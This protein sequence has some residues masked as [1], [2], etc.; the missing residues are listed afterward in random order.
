M[1]QQWNLSFATN[2]DRARALIDW[3][4]TASPNKI[5]KLVPMIGDA[6]F[7]RYFRLYTEGDTYVVMDAPPGVE[8]VL[9]FMRIANVLNA[10]GLEAPHI[11]AQDAQN[12]FLLLSDFGDMTYLNALQTHAPTPL[13][14]KALQAL[15]VLYRCDQQSPFTLP[16]FTHAIMQTE[17][18]LHQRWFLQGLLGLETVDHS[19]QLSY[20]ILV[21]N[22]LLQPQVFM[23][24]DFHAG[25]LMLLPDGKVGLLDFQDA[26]IG[27]ITYDL[28]SLLRDCYVDWPKQQIIEWA[29]FYYSL[30]HSQGVLNDISEL[31]FL[32]WFDLM[33]I[34]RH[35][36]T[37]MTFARKALRDNTKHYL[38]F[39]P[40]TLNYI[41]SVSQLYDELAPL[42]DYYEDTVLPLFKR[43]CI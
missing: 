34:Q 37:L 33:G 21:E 24:R 13:Y 31:Q 17:W 4:A 41:I 42:A 15:A 10:H 18:E 6:S 8:D 40:R 35:L 28:A 12:G 27:P 20:D 39:V 25:N 30:L 1:N 3:L 23:Y 9:R 2:D 26:F 11:F 14:H 22:A 19:L 43:Q 38:S 36:K 7:R 16:H 5:V 32:R 29:L